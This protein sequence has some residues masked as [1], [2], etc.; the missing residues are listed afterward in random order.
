EASGGLCWLWPMLL[1]V[2]RVRK[3]VQTQFL[4]FD[5]A[6]LGSIQQVQVFSGHF[7]LGER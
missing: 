3:P 4:V 6:Q 5:V 7:I 2:Q 1:R